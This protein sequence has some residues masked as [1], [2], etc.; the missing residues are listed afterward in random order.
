MLAP[1]NS[2]VFMNKKKIILIIIAF[3]LVFLWWYFTHSRDYDTWRDNVCLNR[4]SVCVVE[5][6]Y[7]RKKF[8]GLRHVFTWGGGDPQLNMK[9]NIDGEVI[10]WKGIYIPI[11]I[12][13]HSNII[14]MV[15]YDK[16]TDWDNPIFRLYKLTQGSWIEINHSEFP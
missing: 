9:V 11:L 3:L 12:N 5:Y 10:S 8:F 2:V 4:E 16:E 6:S 13:K 15:V 7:S 14:Y 1:E